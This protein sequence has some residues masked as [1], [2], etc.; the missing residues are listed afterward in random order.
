MPDIIVLATLIV[1]LYDTIRDYGLLEILQLV[2]G[3]LRFT[4]VCRL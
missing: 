2:E 3:I 1:D 4:V